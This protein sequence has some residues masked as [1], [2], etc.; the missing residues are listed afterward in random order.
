MNAVQPMAN[1]PFLCHQHRRLQRNLCHL[2]PCATALSP[3]HNIQLPTPLPKMWSG[4]RHGL[5]S[6]TT[7]TATTFII[8]STSDTRT[9]FI[10]YLLA[11][12]EDKEGHEATPQG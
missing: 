11:G 8:P 4:S 1:A 7:T 10:R 12:E 6:M 2:S 5:T 9:L 3:R